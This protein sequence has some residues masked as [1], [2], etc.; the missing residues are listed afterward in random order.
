MIFAKRRGAATKFLIPVAVNA[1]GH[2]L[3]KTVEEVF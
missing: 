3:N 1:L 2:Q